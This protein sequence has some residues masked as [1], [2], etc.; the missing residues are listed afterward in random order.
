MKA[1]LRFATGG[2]SL[3]L[4]A[5]L[6]TAPAQDFDDDDDAIPDGIE[7]RTRGPVHEAFAQPDGI[8]PEPGQA[9]PKQPPAPIPEEPPEERPEGENMQY[10]PGYWAWDPEQNE[11]LWVSGGYRNVPVGR[12]WVPGSWVE[13]EEG[14]RWVPGFWAAEQQDELQYTPEPPAP[15]QVEPSVPAASD[16]TFWVPGTWLYREPQ[17]VWRPGYWSPL[18]ADRVWV[19][20]RYIWTPNGYLFCD[21]YSDYPWEDRGLLFA[22]VHFDR[23]YWHT[24]GWYWRPS[25]VV[26]LGL[27]FDSCFTHHGFFHFHFGNYYG[28]RYHGLGYRPWFDG[29]GRYHSLFAH[30]RWHHHRHDHDWHGRQRELYRD[31]HDGRRHGPPRTW[32]EQRNFA[33][34]KGLANNQP[35]VVA[36]LKQAKAVNKNVNLVK[37]TAPQAAVQKAASARTQTIAQAR[38]KLAAAKK[39]S[40]VTRT[41]PRAKETFKLP[42]LVRGTETVR[43]KTAA[44][45]GP[46]ARGNDV[47][48]KKKSDA[49]LARPGSDNDRKG[50]AGPTFATPKGNLPKGKPAKSNPAAGNNVP[51][52]TNPYAAK[53]GITPRVIDTTPPVK[54]KAGAPKAPVINKP[55]N[56]DPSPLPRIQQNKAQP[57]PK[58]N[59][60]KINSA[61]K[62]NTPPKA[63]SSVNFRSPARSNQAPALP[64]VNAAPKVKSSSPAPRINTG[65]KFSNPA[66]KAKAPAPRAKFSSPAPRSFNPPRSAPSA[67]R[68]APRAAPRP[69]PRSS[70]PAPRVSPPRVSAPSRGSP[71]RSF[72]APRSGSGNPGKSRRK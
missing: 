17:W 46:G 26:S 13:T 6:G 72:A 35:R 52:G 21:G 40:G 41:A 60:P 15:L 58:F 44:P 49:K 27:F 14:W 42:P 30:H 67:P 54:P 36:S 18:R 19:A 71:G 33:K 37:L 32:A 62:V 10:V 8:R 1:F 64:K 12:Q 11:F 25:H 31:R 29:H 38:A 7:I 5:F 65:P 22:P 57:Q 69:A 24:P 59:A 48:S 2:G 68:A 45:T 56:L 61:P 51:K 3:F 23:P 50:P 43:P 47:G 16:D 66:P 53:K 34:N 28:P 55:R 39:V 70:S 63:K 20:A 9:I 4:L